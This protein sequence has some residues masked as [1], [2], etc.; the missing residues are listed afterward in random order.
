MYH[1]DLEVP[2]ERTVKMSRVPEQGTYVRTQ[3]VKV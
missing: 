1:R 2:E 3:M